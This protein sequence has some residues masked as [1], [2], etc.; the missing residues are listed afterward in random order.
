MLEGS[1]QS[2]Y[3]VYHQ[4]HTLLSLAARFLNN[5]ADNNLGEK[6][7]GSWAELFTEYIPVDNQATGSYYE[8]KK[9]MRNLGLPF[10]TIDVC[11]NIYMIF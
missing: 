11:I 7:M 1:K 6:C 9:L 5:K 10:Y 2:L 3:D 8:I 4:G